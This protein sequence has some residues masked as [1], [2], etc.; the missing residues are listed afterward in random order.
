MSFKLVWLNVIVFGMSCVA[1]AQD[2]RTANYGGFSAAMGDNQYS[3]AFDFSH[4]WKMGKSGKFEI[5]FGGRLTSFFGSKKYY[6]SAPANLASNPASTDSI[7]FYDAQSNSLNA[8]LN[9][10]Y[11]FGGH[12]GVGFNIDVIGGSFGFT[13]STGHIPAAPGFV[14]T[15]NSSPTPFNLLLIDNHD[16]GNLNSEFSV[17]Y[18]LTD[19]VTIKLIY[20]HLFTEFTT[21][22]VVQQLPEPNDRFRYKGNLFGI[23][24]YQRF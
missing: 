19:K 11:R 9:F 17:R 21:H 23:G 24:V 2:Q 16:M 22:T 7:Y 14:G 6:T 3:F 5:G 20:Q 1:I 12:F 10:G 8:T 4:L 13:Q 18:F 15:A